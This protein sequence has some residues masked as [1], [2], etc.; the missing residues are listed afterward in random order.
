MSIATIRN[1]SKVP[2]YFDGL[3]NDSDAFATDASPNNPNITG[4]VLPQNF[5]PPLD[6]TGSNAD[7][8][9]G[10][11]YWRFIFQRHGRAI[12]V[13]F[14]D[15]HAETVPLEQLFTL[16]WTLNWQPYLL[17]AAPNGPLSISQLLPK[18]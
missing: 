13:V 6:L 15:G 10:P 7:Q 17:L 2:M 18:K 4:L 12:N 14:L 9:P 1:S 8:N 5:Q 16:Q 3:W 11:K